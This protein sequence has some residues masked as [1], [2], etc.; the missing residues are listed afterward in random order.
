MPVCGHQCLS[1]VDERAREKT[2]E[3]VHVYMCHMRLE[4]LGLRR[5]KPFFEHTPE[6]YNDFIRLR[7]QMMNLGRYTA[8]SSV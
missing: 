8:L 2:I 1:Q 6:K 4:D 3:N 7:N 5:W